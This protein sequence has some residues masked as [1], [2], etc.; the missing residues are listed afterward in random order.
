LQ[1]ISAPGEGAQIRISL[2]LVDTDPA[3][4]AS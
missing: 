2:P 4:S 3:S 1:M